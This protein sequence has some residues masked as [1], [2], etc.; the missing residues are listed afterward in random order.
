MLQKTPELINELGKT[1]GYKINTQN[2]LHFYIITKDQKEKLN[3]QP[4]VPSHKKN[5]IPTNKLT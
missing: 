5:K 4:H 1:A 3:K 2:L